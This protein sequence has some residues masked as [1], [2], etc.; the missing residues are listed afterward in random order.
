MKFLIVKNKKLF[1][2]TSGY[3]FIMNIIS[4]K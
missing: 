4:R 1:K 2:I 3:T